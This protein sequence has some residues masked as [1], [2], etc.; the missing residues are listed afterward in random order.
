MSARERKQRIIVN[1]IDGFRLKPRLSNGP[2][3][4]A[5][6]GGLEATLA[7]FDVIKHQPGYL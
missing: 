3:H 4:G 7:I 6:G 5:A 1:I 2:G